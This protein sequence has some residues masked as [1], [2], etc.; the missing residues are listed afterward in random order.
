MRYDIIIHKGTDKIK[1]GLTSKEVQKVLGELPYDTYE[2]FEMYENV[3]VEYDKSGRSITMEF[4][5]TVQVYLDNVALTNQRP[6]L[7]MDLL[8]KYDSNLLVESPKIFQSKILSIGCYAED[9]NTIEAVLVGV[10][11]YYDKF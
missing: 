7:A 11:G 1:L 4:F 8:K 5:N 9:S 10:K 3:R 6:E 2:Q